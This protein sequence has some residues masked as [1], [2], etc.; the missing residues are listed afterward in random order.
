MQML[1]SPI[2]ALNVRESPKFTRVMGNRK[3]GTIW[4]RQIVDRK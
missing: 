1:S 4:W 2:S 3:R